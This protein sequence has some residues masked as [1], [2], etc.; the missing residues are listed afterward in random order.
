MDDTLD[1]WRAGR[2]G[3]TAM[4]RRIAIV[5]AATSLMGAAAI[6]A[7]A[8]AAEHHGGGGFSHGGLG[9]GSFAARGVARSFATPGVVGGPRTFARG[10]FAGR[11]FEPGFRRHRFA[12]FGLPVFG[13]GL[14]LG[15]YGYYDDPC[16]A[17]TPYG[18]R[19]V[20]GYDY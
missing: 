4:L 7:D 19:W 3:S 6:P 1:H 11:G 18:Y 13:L 2:E 17:W 15:A 14:G 20:C 12:R 10:G 8:L 16:Y 9:G 5:L